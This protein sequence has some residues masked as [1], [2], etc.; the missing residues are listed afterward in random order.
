MPEQRLSATVMMEMALASPQTIKD[1]QTNTE[2]TLR[3]LEAQVVERFPDPNDKTAS[4]LW[5]IV[6]VSFALVLVFCA[7]VLGTGVTEKLDTGA[8]YAVKSDTIL[9]LFTTVV[10]FLAGLLAPSPVSKKGA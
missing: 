2:E 9:T 10:G 3:K 1:L 7:W 4:R 5:L 8:T 6:V